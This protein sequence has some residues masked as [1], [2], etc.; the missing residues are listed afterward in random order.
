MRFS[1]C[2]RAMM[3]RNLYSMIWPLM[4]LHNFCGE[5]DQPP[6]LAI[7]LSGECRTT[8]GISNATIY[9]RDAADSA[10]IDWVMVSAGWMRD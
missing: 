8:L 2:F 1:M 6:L 3:A 7:E 9:R 4:R 5:H 10:L